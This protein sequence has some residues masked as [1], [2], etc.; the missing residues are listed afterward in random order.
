LR[1]SA[2]YRRAKE[3]FRI[4]DSRALA[5]LIACGIAML[6]WI[7]APD[8][9]PFGARAVQ[10]GALQYF[11][12]DPIGKPIPLAEGQVQLADPARAGEIA[13]QLHFTIS[14]SDGA[15]FYMP[16]A[17]DD[18]MLWVNG[19]VGGA[20]EE[21]D[22]LGPGFGRSKVSLE[23]PSSKLSFDA[24]RVDIVSLGGWSRGRYPLIYAIPARNAPAFWVAS[25]AAV[26]HLQF[27]AIGF[28]GLGLV[29]ALIGLLLLRSKILCLGG[30]LFSMALIDM[31]VGVMPA[32]VQLGIMAAGIALLMLAGWRHPALAGASLAGSAAVIAG[33]AILAGW[34]ASFPFLWATNFAFW[35]LAGIAL[36]WLVIAECQSLLNEFIAARTKIR[37]Q[38]DVIVQQQAEL[39][40][41]I[42]AHAIGE[43]RQRFV[44]D[45]HD[46][47]GGHLLSL[48]MRV[49]ADEADKDDV[50]AELEKGLTDLRLIADSLDHVGQ[51]L[52][53]AL[54]AFQRRAAQQLV[55]AGLEFDWVKPDSLSHFQL[56]ARAV[57]NL[58]RI[59]QEALS[60]CIRHAHASR[61]GVTFS[62]SDTADR[63]HLVIE[64][65]GIGFAPESTNEGRGL[66][67]IRKRA[68]KLG[69]TLAIGV[70]GEGNGTRILLNV[71]AS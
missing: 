47:V 33:F 29:A 1:L 60:N 10:P 53:F 43:E 70:G 27:G 39:E 31:A 45:M 8:L 37:E 69:G 57:L 5:L 12:G 22:Y 50:A 26:R 18:A 44:R 58:Y 17:P 36:P 3:K 35:P 61:F 67:N 68:E 25:A 23:I 19:M 52:D 71:P 54:A 42:R 21:T 30:A 40:D 66:A 15:A 34:A 9:T 28:G 63:F 14:A 62:Q 48:L 59:M 6:A 55:S 41:S 20:S 56:D 49:R 16:A 2:L 46:G 24:N 32:G 51:D 11:P 64:D 65:D 13:R 7:S 4:V 38:A